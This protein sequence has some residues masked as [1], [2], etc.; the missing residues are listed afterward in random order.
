MYDQPQTG[1][2]ARG[3]R[4]CLAMF[5]LIF[6]ALEAVVKASIDKHNGLAPITIIWVMRMVIALIWSV[7][8]HCF[9]PIF[10]RGDGLDAVPVPDL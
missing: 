5:K 7:H 1:R 2:R 8:D 10:G 9:V 4:L 6:W 3:A